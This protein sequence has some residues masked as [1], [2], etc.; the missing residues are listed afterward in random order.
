MAQPAIDRS[1]GELPP[2]ER[3]V[4][5]EMIERA[6][7]GFSSGVGVDHSVV[8]AWLRTWGQVGR[9]PFKEWLA[10]WDG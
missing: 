6:K 10:A 7:E 3:P 1:T 9:R 8:S 2:S 5:R 4:A